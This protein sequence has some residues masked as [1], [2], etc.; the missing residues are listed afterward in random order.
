MEL[1]LSIRSDNFYRLMTKHD[2]SPE[3]SPITN[4]RFEGEIKREDCSTRI[5]GNP[6]RYKT[7][8]DKKQF[9]KEIE[10]IL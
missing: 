7:E 6:G 1:L 10:R 4:L 5:S 8:C 9:I 2:E 3:D